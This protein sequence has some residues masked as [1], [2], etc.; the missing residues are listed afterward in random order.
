[1]LDKNSIVP[2]P[3]WCTKLSYNYQGSVLLMN[4]DLSKVVAV[5]ITADGSVALI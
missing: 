3:S 1:M 2:I 5:V 4:D